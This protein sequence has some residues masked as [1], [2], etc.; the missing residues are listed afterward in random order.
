M[1]KFINRITTVAADTSKHIVGANYIG[2][3]L[4]VISAFFGRETTLYAALVA[5]VSLFLWEFYF[6]ITE[7]KPFSFK[8]VLVAVIV[9]IPY[10]LTI[11]LS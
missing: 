8:D 2:W 7:K 6:M 5:V 4:W 9:L 3:V 1:I 10:I 11:H